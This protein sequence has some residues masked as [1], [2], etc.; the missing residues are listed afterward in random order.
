MGDPHIESWPMIHG[1]F[2]WAKSF[3][4]KHIGLRVIELGTLS[5]IYFDAVLI[6]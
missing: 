4:L 2:R 3:S 5:I 1:Y 6:L